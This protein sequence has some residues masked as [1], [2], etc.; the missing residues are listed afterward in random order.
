LSCSDSNKLIM[1]SIRL[2][3]LLAQS[4][5]LF[6]EQKPSL[7]SGGDA[8]GGGEDI[9]SARFAVAAL[10][11]LSFLHDSDSSLLSLMPPDIE[12]PWLLNSFAGSAKDVGD[13]ARL[14][15]RTLA[16]RLACKSVLS[17][18]SP[19]QLP[20]ALQV[21]KHVMIS[22]CWAD[23]A[24]PEIVNRLG[25]L[26]RD[27]GIDV[28]MDQSGSSLVGPMSDSTDETMALAVEASS[29]VIVCVSQKYKREQQQVNLFLIFSSY[30]QVQ[31]FSQLPSRSC[32]SCAFIS[33]NLH[34]RDFVAYRILTYFLQI[35]PT[36]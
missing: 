8:K 33:C 27:N 16:K 4:L 25:Q 29:A 3:R 24:K 21:Q 19:L 11:Q 9:P 7:R 35:C 15:A 12:L 36:T 20:S 10:V 28:W 34:S 26:L 1:G 14:H 13:D 17:K 32:V 23:A 6:V 30:V 31:S 2:V 22:Y 18:S 5:R